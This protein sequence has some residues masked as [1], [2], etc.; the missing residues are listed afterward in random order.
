MH[1]L[2]KH[3]NPELDQYIYAGVTLSNV[4][5]DLAVKNA[6]HSFSSC[7]IENSI[8]RVNSDSK[9]TP[10]M[11]NGN[12]WKNCTFIP[13]RELSLATVMADFINCTFH[14]KW[15]GRIDGVVNGCD[16]S[17]SELVNFAFYNSTGCIFP[18]TNTIV[19][20]D[21]GKHNSEIKALLKGISNI[22]LHIRPELKQFAFS[23]EKQKKKS[24][25]LKI[26]GT[27]DYVQ[28]PKA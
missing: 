25:V 10:Y 8:V 18:N 20:N 14:G 9:A 19:I 7:T 17:D 1:D 24:E 27:L 15:S 16:F 13:K 11:L 28:L 12:V 22:G 21:A 2:L 23:L 6:A 4:E 5:I 26:L 3:N